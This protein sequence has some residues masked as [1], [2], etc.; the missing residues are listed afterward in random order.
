MHSFSTDVHWMVSLPIGLFSIYDAIV[1][2][3]GLFFYLLVAS[4]DVVPDWVDGLRG[5][6]CFLYWFLH[7]PHVLLDF[8]HIFF[9]PFD[10]GFENPWAAIQ[11]ISLVLQVSIDYDVFLP[12]RKG[13]LIN[14]G[15]DL[16]HHHPIFVL[17]VDFVKTHPIFKLSC[18]HLHDSRSIYFLFM[19]DIRY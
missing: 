15:V 5:T 1:I 4:L 10:I 17:N 14:F 11:D 6:F 9:Y 2:T 3:G 7:N 19:A 8:Y 12:I 18:L 16:T 13:S